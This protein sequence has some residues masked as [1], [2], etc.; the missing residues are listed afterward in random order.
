GLE[1]LHVPCPL[2]GGPM[3]VL[4]ARSTDAFPVAPSFSRTLEQ[5]DVLT[6]GVRVRGRLGWP[7]RRAR[8]SWRCCA[9]D[10]ELG[11]SEFAAECPV[12]ECCEQLV[13]GVEGAGDAVALG[14]DCCNLCGEIALEGEGWNVDLKCGESTFR[15]YGEG[16][17][18]ACSGNLI[19]HQSQLPK[20]KSVI[21]LVAPLNGIDLLIERA[22]NCRL[23]DL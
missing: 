19:A 13:V 20:A 18:R 5:A 16:G 10:A 21:N 8:S 4:A 3:D 9:V 23:T 7:I 12:L 14:V 17:R 2:T 22:R 11:R 6:L 1:G 15:Q